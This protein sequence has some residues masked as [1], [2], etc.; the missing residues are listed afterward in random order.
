ME[1]RMS[2]CRPTHIPVPLTSPRYRERTPATEAEQSAMQYVYFRQVLD[3]LLYIS[4]RTNPDVST[5]V[6]MLSTFQTEQILRD[7]K[8]LGA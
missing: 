2:D 4:T 5:A 6:S 3:S 1:V 7:S 8:A